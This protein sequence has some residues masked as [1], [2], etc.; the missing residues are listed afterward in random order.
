VS[1]FSRGKRDEISTTLTYSGNHERSSATSYININKYIAKIA[2]PK[3]AIYT[4]KDLKN[5]AN[6][7]LTVIAP[8]L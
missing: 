3:L 2:M 6:K 4:L 1:F 8:K 7:A 5:N